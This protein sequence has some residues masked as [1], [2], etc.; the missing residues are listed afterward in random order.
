MER[1]R[2]IVER[3]RSR[4]DSIQNHGA[5][6]VD[7]ATSAHAGLV[8][9]TERQ[10]CNSQDI[11]LRENVS[12][13]IYSW[14]FGQPIRGALKNRWEMDRQQYCAAG[15]RRYWKQKMMVRGGLGALRIHG[16]YHN[17]G[18]ALG[19]LHRALRYGAD[20]DQQERWSN[21]LFENDTVEEP[22][23]RSTVNKSYMDRRRQGL[24][25]QQQRQ[26]G[27]A[28]VQSRSSYPVCGNDH[29]GRMRAWED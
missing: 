24:Q 26:G 14:E 29:S 25:Q 10:R 5:S 16:P 23:R 6:R 9:A 21:D 11:F 4:D 17:S 3:S 22:Y 19:D 18:P 8:Q 7:R 20:P 28:S 27:S 12:D 1:S 2:G 13:E 15:D